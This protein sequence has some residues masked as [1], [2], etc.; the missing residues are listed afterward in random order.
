[1]IVFVYLLAELL[2][3][4]LI[5]IELDRQFD[6]SMCSSAIAFCQ[7]RLG[8]KKMCLGVARIDILSQAEPIFGFLVSIRLQCDDT[9]IV[10][11]PLV[12]WIDCKNCSIKGRGIL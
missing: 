10:E 8:E 5:G 2:E 7:Q 6:V 3:L 4:C 1:M 12:V 9:E 11:R